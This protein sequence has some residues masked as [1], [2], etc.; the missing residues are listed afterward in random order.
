MENE[1]NN[2]SDEGKGSNTEESDVHHG[3]EHYTGNANDISLL[4]DISTYSLE[5]GILFHSLVIGIALG[6]ASGTE[7]VSLLI[8][9]CFHQLFEGIALGIRIGELHTSFLKKII[10]GVIYPFTTPAGITIGV[11]TSSSMIVT[12]YSLLFKGIVNSL[13][14]GIL[15]YNTYVELI[16]M[17]INS[18]RDFRFEKVLLKVFCFVALYLGAA[19]MGILALWA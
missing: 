17:D 2:D 18:N 5:A 4:N 14:A 11:L 10:F 9:I 13:S 1:N 12:P 16:G 19:A 7:F 3:H 6:V 8:A 15:I